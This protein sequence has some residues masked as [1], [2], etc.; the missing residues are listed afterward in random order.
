MIGRAVVETA[1]R[2]AIRETVP[3]KAARSILEY[4]KVEWGGLIKKKEKKQ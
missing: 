1:E 4:K 3:V 2:T